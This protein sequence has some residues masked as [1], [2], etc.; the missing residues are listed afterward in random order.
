M[1]RG[2]QM[3]CLHGV[4]GFTPESGDWQTVMSEPTNNNTIPWFERRSKRQMSSTP[5]I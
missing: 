4:Y 2:F 1:I 3:S 5:G